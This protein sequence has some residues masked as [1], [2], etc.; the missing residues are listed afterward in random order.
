[1][2]EGATCGLGTSTGELPITLYAYGLS[3]RK[4]F[5][6]TE[7]MKKR[8]LSEQEFLKRVEPRFASAAAARAWFETE[9]LPG[10]SGQTAQQLVA[11]GRASDV[12][13]L[14]SAVDAGVYS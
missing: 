1:M 4:A 9:P 10:F 6:H 5:R 11:A 12:V 2:A 7:F 14:L 8:A 13:E 3:S